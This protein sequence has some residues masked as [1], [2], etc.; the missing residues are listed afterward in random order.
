MYILMIWSER[1]LFVRFVDI[2]GIVDHYCLNFL[3]IFIIFIFVISIGYKTIRSIDL[4]WDNC[5]LMLT[6]GEG[7]FFLLFLLVFIFRRLFFPFLLLF[8]FFLPLFFDLFLLAAFSAFCLVIFAS[9][10][11]GTLT[12]TEEDFFP[13]SVLYVLSMGFPCLNFFEGFWKKTK[14]AF[15]LLCRRNNLGDFIHCKTLQR[16]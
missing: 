14:D 7:T 11:D 8:F 15:I 4:S 9:S 5:T 2:G 3:F 12:I 6:A 13:G 16:I 10:P 1:W